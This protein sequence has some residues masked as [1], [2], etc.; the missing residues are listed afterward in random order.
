MS[1]EN[2]TQVYYS[3]ENFERLRRAQ[4]LA[5]RKNVTVTQIGLAYVLQQAFPVIAL[6]GPATV[7]NLD[8]ALGAL[9]VEL[10]P[11]EM[12]FLELNIQE[13]REI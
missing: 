1:D 5:N 13:G 12:D 2:A 3:E 6:V 8:D 4:I 11:E 7:G 10:S 9:D